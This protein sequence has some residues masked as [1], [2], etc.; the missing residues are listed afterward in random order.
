M[1]QTPKSDFDSPW[2]EIIEAFFPQFM[3]FFVPDSVKEI[4]WS[5]KIKFLDKEFQKITKNSEVGKRYTDKL[6]E[7]TLKNNQTKQITRL[8]LL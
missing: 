2:K 4:D 6:V 5:K 7:V 3:E 8:P 1:K